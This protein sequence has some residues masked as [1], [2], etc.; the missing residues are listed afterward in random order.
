ML[1]VQL[2]THGCGLQQH[3]GPASQSPEPLIKSRPI[4][5]LS[6]VARAEQLHPK[7][8]DSQCK[9]TMFGTPSQ[10]RLSI[11]N[12]EDIDAT[13]DEDRSAAGKTWICF[14]SGLL[15]VDLAYRTLKTLMLQNILKK[16]SGKTIPNLPRTF[17]EASSVRTAQ[18]HTVGYG[19]TYV[20]SISL[21]TRRSVEERREAEVTV[22]EAR[23]TDGSFG[24]KVMEWPPW[25]KKNGHLTPVNA[26][27][28][29][30]GRGGRRT[31][32]ESQG[33]LG[34]TTL[35]EQLKWMIPYEIY[36]CILQYYF[37]IPLHVVH[38][39]LTDQVLLFKLVSGL[40]N[41]QLLTVV[42]RRPSSC[43]PYF[44]GMG[45]Q[46]PGEYAGWNSHF[47]HTLHSNFA[48]VL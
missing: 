46:A 23:I 25:K 7:L 26:A 15:W 44:N 10:V 9:I 1:I 40:G 4:R 42:P 37:V 36:L 39:I 20:R 18:S 11:G 19:E 47:T 43:G 22:G 14:F 33:L 38:C 13:I 12:L 29:D 16:R 17:E 27:L 28:L 45:D 48:V 2:N 31:S 8:G 3:L 5:C 6:L 21:R 34:D 35:N 24:P 30:P 32:G 41:K